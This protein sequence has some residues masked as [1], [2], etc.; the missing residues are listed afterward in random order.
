M[1]FAATP[2]YTDFQGLTALRAEAR[3]APDESL[4][5]VAAQF[6]SLFVQMMLKSMRE[7]TIDGGLFE[8]NELELYQEMYD[9]QISLDMS[10]KSSLGLADILVQQLGGNKAEVS[11]GD[12][13]PGVFPYSH[14]TGPAITNGPVSSAANTTL[15]VGQNFQ[16]AVALQ[17]ALAVPSAPVPVA[18]KQTVEP[19]V[20][21]RPSR[22]DWSPASPEEFIRSVWDQ[23]VEASRDLGLDPLV[24]V[25]QSA[26]ETGWGKKVIRNGDG[27]SSFNLFGIKAGGGWAGDSTAVNT[28]EF[29]DGIAAMEKAAFRVYDSLASS[30]EDYVSFLKGNPRYQQALEKVDDAKEFLQELQFSGYATDPQYAEKILG[31][32]SKGSFEA[33]VNELKNFQNVSLS[34]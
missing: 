19:V 33:V 11:Q 29:R 15:D 25:A 8:S 23:A 1:S 27:S 28:L 22:A 3:A 21:S 12:T 34:P 14:S 6:E 9:K 4:E 20:A 2:V 24:L 10:T 5:K 30:F 17:I 18:V 31:I 13:P 32:L 26:L 7:A 16:A